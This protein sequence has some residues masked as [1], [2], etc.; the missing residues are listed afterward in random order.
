MLTQ[1]CR[2]ASGWPK[3]IGLG[4]MD[5]MDLNQPSK[6]VCSSSGENHFASLDAQSLLSHAHCIDASDSSSKIAECAL[7]V[8]P[9]LQERD[10]VFS[11]DSF[12]R[13][14]L[15]QY[16]SISSHIL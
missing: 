2:T 12:V 5:P 13:S 7:G 10:T 3:A 15:W 11:S 16:W 4:R 8:W 9:Q 6:A 14:M 1:W